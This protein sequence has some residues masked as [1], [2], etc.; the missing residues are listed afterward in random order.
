VS[1]QANIIP[2]ANGQDP[3]GLIVLLH[4]WGANL[5]DLAPLGP[6][7]N[8]PEYQFIC[9]DAPFPHPEVPGGM[10]WYDLQSED[11]F[12][13]PESR[14]LL[15]DWLNSLENSTGVPLSRTILSGFSQG[16]AMIL[17]VGVKLP[18]AGLVSMS[19][20]LHA[21]PE[22][23]GD[24]LPP[25]LIMHGRQDPVVPLRAAH[26]ARDMYQLLGASVQYHEFDMSHEIR[27]EE[28]TLIRDFIS[29]II[30]IAPGGS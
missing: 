7:L 10:M 9:P 23:V 19:G 27:P 24:R 14:Q 16:G 4:G 17:D 2:P 20:Y 21:A 26:Q 28:L 11:Y 25:L 18:V 22:P 3:Q 1:L 8:L 12:G 29:Q 6:A 5:H 13:L 15:V 30:S